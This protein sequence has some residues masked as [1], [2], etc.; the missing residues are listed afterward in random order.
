M[1]SKA[2]VEYVKG[3]VMALEGDNVVAEAMRQMNPDVVAAY[4]VTPQTEI[5]M[6]FSEF[7]ADG[8]VDTEFV[9]VESEHAAMSA[10]VGS[11][12]AGARTQT[13][14]CG[15]GLA[16]MWE[17]LWVASGMRLPLVMHVSNRA[18]NAPL[19]I[20]CS[21]DDAM[22][23]R[24]IGWLQMF[25]ETHQ[26]AYDNAIQ[27]VRIAEHPDIMLPVM[28]CLDGFVLSHTLERVEIL[29]DDVVK[30]F[31][32]TYKPTH[33]VLDVE[34]PVTYGCLAGSDWYFE[35]KIP[36]WEA[37]K[38]A[39]GV[40]LDVA[41]EWGKLTGRYYDL[42]EPYRLED[43]E[44]A[45]VI[46]GATAGAVRVAIDEMRD[47]G[48][49]AG[50]LKIRCF[51]PF[52][53]ADI[54]KHL[55]GRKVVAVLE[56]CGCFGAEASPVFLE[57]AAALFLRNVRVELV[58]YTYGLGGRDTVPAQI[59]EVFQDLV[60]VMKTG[61]AEPRFRYLGLRDY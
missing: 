3:E 18:F 25:A 42:V 6:T 46:L 29:P 9:P 21:H 51:R 60:D 28:A 1:S 34:H 33:S 20:L 13:A 35:H 16:L 50:M 8:R 22:G 15:P 14:T 7:V 30:R 2:G 24:D 37:M 48:V 59:V 10:C 40:I 45:I 23:S 27:A 4:P 26:E 11:C 12:A 47:R 31:I 61:A 44:V 19:N 53:A 58:N 5:V 49:K 57:I 43:A 36:Q 38:K 52:P 32:G 17:I 56:R 55:K 41:E 54:V 39:P